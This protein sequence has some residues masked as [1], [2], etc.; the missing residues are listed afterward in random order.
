MFVTQPKAIIGQPS[1][2]KYVLNATNSPTVIRPAMTSRLPIHSTSRA[3]MPIS[4]PIL[5][6]YMPCNR[7]SARLRTTYSSFAR[8][9]RSI[10]ND[11][12]PYARTTRTPA[13]DSWVTA[14][15]SESCSWIFS[16][17]W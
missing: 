11:S 15:M 8:R 14:L 16:K 9:N 5:G 4:S 7:I 10:S 17:R 13:S 1:I 3:P 2:I 6:K 12:C